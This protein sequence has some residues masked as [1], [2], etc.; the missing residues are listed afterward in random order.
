MQKYASVRG[1]L[2][3]SVQTNQIPSRNPYRQRQSVQD[4]E[5]KIVASE[6]AV[7]TLPKI[8]GINGKQKAHEKY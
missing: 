4:R 2:V 3:H 6:S 5:R 1:V 8:K 7:E